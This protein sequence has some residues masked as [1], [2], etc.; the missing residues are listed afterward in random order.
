MVSSYYGYRIHPIS[1]ENQLHNGLD[2]AA[3]AGTPVKAGLTGRVTSASYN[4]SYGNYVILEDSDGYEIRY[5]H[6]NSIS[7]SAGASIEKGDENRNSGQ[8]RQFYWKPP[9]Y[10][11]ASQWRTSESYLLFRDRRRKYL[12]R[13]CGVFF[14]SGQKIV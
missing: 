3:P 14:R 8:Y 6:L 4:D 11:T 9:A 13:R 10:R 12:W 5:A 7:V 1:G 2:I